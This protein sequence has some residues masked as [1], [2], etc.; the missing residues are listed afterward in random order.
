DLLDVGGGDFA[1]VARVG[2]AEVVAQVRGEQP[3]GRGD[4]RARRDQD[5]GDL[6]D[7]G[8]LG[9]LGRATAAEGGEQE[10]ARVETALDRPRAQRRGHVLVDD[11][12]DRG[13]RLDGAHA[14]PL[15]EPGDGRLGRLAVELEAA[16]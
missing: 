13:G 9:R 1:G 8:E 4:A 14:H 16:G 15:G 2:L 6:E 11:A 10:L 7:A 5:A 12:D 3:G